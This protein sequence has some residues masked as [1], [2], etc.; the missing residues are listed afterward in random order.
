MRGFP[1]LPV[2]RYVYDFHEPAS[3]GREL[4]GDEHDGS[5]HPAQSRRAD[6][7]GSGAT[8]RV[9]PRLSQPPPFRLDAFRSRAE[10]EIPGDD[11]DEAL[12][13]FGLQYGSAFRAVTRVWRSEGEALG[14]LHLPEDLGGT[15]G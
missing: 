1:A 10:E 12:G 9:A 7:S 14:R 15:D 4:L 5:G 6:M 13:E 8:G 11:L 2:Q 3:G